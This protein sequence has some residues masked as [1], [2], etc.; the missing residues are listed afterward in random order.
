MGFSFW[1]LVL[2]L[3]LV[4][5]TAVMFYD[6]SRAARLADAAVC[7]VAFVRGVFELYG[8]DVKLKQKVTAPIFGSFFD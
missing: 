6:R 5:A 3:A 2:L 8:L 1:W 4:I 7:G